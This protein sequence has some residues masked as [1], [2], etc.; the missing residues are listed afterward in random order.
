MTSARRARNERRA[1]ARQAGTIERPA[2][3]LDAAI[4]ARRA[5]SGMLLRGIVLVMLT[6]AGLLLAY[7]AYSMSPYT[8]ASLPI[9]SRAIMAHG[10][11]AAAYAWNVRTGSRYIPLTIAAVAGA[12]LL[13]YRWQ[14]AS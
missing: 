2:R 11:L 5:L 9:L 8:Q 10:V 14:V 1:A 12:A 6:A 3:V 7:G 4:V 13:V